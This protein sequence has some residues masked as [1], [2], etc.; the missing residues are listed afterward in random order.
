[1]MEQTEHRR[2]RFAVI[3][4]GGRGE[5]LWPVSTSERPKQFLRFG[6]CPNTMLQQTFARVRAL[7]HSDDTY[8][9]VPQDFL[10]LVHEQLGAEI[11]EGNI[12]AEPIGRNTA[13]CV[14]LAAIILEARDPQAVMV[15]LPADHAVKERDRFLDVLRVATALA[16]QQAGYLITLG[17][18]PDRPATGYGY[19]QRGQRFAVE[20]GVE[21]FR[22]EN[23]AEKPDV[24]K[25]RRFLAAGSYLWNSGMFIWRVDSILGAI[26]R[27]MPTLFAGLQEAKQHLGRPDF[28]EVVKRVYLAQ[29]SVPIDRGVLERYTRLLVIPADIGWSDVGDWSAMSAL[30]ET[31]PDGNVAWGNHTGV[32]TRDSVI[33]SESSGKRIVTIGLRDMVVVETRDVLLVMPKTRS[34]DVRA[35]LT[36][37]VRHG[38]NTAASTKPRRECQ[39]Q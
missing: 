22:V 8:V 7:F 6:G 38:T 3:M 36:C 31:D 30:F 20:G 39:A 10:G 33:Y 32:D 34:Q 21:V 19:I 27:C 14:G 9:V 2:R 28:G 4:A 18:T 12:I 26:E 17:I 1:M 24:D 29:D 23:F 5:R 11:P 15:V 35:V 13:A 25:A 37:V 16:D